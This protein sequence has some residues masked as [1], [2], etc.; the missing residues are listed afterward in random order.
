MARELISGD[1]LIR[2]IKPGDARK[3]LLDG[4]GLYLLLFV[5]GGAHGWRFD[6]S[7]GGVRKTISLGTYPETGLGLAR[8]KAD[9]ARSLVSEGIDPSGVRKE[10]RAEAVEQREAQRRADAGLPAADSFEAVT[11]EWMERVHRFKVSAGHAERT[12]TRLQQDVFPWLGRVSLAEIKAPAILQCLRRVEARGALETAHRVKQA[13]GQVFRYGIATGRCDRDPSADLRDALAPV[14][15]KHHAAITDPK[16]TGELLRAIDDYQGH[17]VTR[18]ALQLAALVF[19]RPGELRSAQWSEVDLEKAMWTI[20]SERMKRSKMGKASGMPHLV[21]LSRQ[22]VEIL[23]DLR[24]LTGHGLYVFPSARTDD[25][26]MSDNA[27]LAALRRMGFGKDEMT[28][29]GVRAMART[30]LVERLGVDENIVEAQLA[31]AVKDAL[32]RAY[33]RTEYV[34]QRRSMM[35]VWADYLDRLRAGAEVLQLVPTAA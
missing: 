30:M 12:L 22:A 14:Y 33:N 10:K 8:R 32:G 3:R 15:V 20:P 7:I 1:A 4:A 26:P 2:S 18:A 34:A 9:E 11:L 13:C 28:G 27:V 24:P 19:Q 16:R 31:H 21:P 29:H 25:R 5:K 35:Q 17:P 23:A 6:Y